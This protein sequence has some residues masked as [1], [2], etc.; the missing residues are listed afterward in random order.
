MFIE[1]V[2]LSVFCVR[3]LL[4]PDEPRKLWSCTWFSNLPSHAR[5]GVHIPPL[6]LRFWP[7]LLILILILLLL[8]HLPLHPSKV[9]PTLS[10]PKVCKRLAKKEKRK[11]WETKFGIKMVLYIPS[12]LPSQA[13]LPPPSKTHM[14]SFSCLCSLRAPPP[15]LLVGE[16]PMRTVSTKSTH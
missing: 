9:L 3:I 8:P 6:L 7:P 10:R 16:P 11:K 2:F 15:L 4:S 5:L 12:S 1:L 13:T 14:Y